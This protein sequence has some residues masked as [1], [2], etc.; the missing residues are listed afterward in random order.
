VDGGLFFGAA[1]AAEGVHAAPELEFRFPPIHL[2][3]E[4]LEVEFQLGTNRPAMEGGMMNITDVPFALG[5]GREK[6]QLL[7]L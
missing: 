6:D 1:F 2:R 5:S 7:T 3:R 4:L